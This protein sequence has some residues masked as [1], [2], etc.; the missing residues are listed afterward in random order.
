MNIDN[1]VS[2]FID[3]VKVPSP[4]YK[5]GD[6]AKLLIEDLLNLGFEVQMDNAGENYNSD[7]GNIIGYLKGN[8]DAEP[9]ILCSHMDTVTPCYGIEPIIENDIIRSSNNTILSADDKAGIVSILEGIRYIKEN[10]IPHGDIE[11]LFTTCEEVGL[12][13]AKNLD[14]S[15]IKSKKAFVL[16]GS[17]DVGEVIVQGPA[18]AV[19]TAKITG[20]SAHAGINPENGIN[21]IQIA[22]RAIDM[23]NLLRIDDETTANVGRI[24]GGN[25]TNIVPD[26]AEIIFECR[27]LNEHKFNMQISHMVRI[28]N[29]SADSFGGKVDINIENTYPAFQLSLDEDILKLIEKA[30]NLIDITYNP[31]STSGGSD[32]NILNNNGI[33]A[34]TLG[35]GLFNAHSTSEYISIESLIKTSKLVAS[36]IRSV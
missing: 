14:Y 9:I 34:I 7:T 36:I 25:E 22:A 19:I 20:K 27:S 31:I 26:F 35:I 28:L 21:A 17:G 3:Y 23:M 11:V 24:G 2:R 4:S 16:D 13:G 10:N 29:E 32:T 8:K 1:I 33:K 5:E 12:L 6:F 15:K 30:M 18:H